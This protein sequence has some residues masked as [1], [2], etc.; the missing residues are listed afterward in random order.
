MIDQNEVTT[1]SQARRL[2]TVN[3]EIAALLR[4]PEVVQRLRA[5]GPDEWSAVQIVG[6]MNEMIPYWM[7]HVRNLAAAAGDPPRFGRMLDAPERLDAVAHGA[8]SDPD[9]LLRQ[10]DAVVR[11]AAADI[12]RLSPAERAKTGIHVRRGEMTVAAVIEDLVV[13]HAEEHQA[14]V[15]QVLGL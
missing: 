3:V 13:T 12:R 5:A 11:S 4:R 2:E 7:G 10:L 9:D 8:L 6:H 15:K 1:E 14:Q